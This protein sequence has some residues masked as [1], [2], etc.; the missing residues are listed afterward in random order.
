MPKRLPPHVFDSSTSRAAARAVQR[1]VPSIARRVF[2]A[3][4]VNPA[5]CKELERSLKLLHE[6]ASA[7]VSELRTAGCIRTSGAT[8]HSS[9]LAKADVYE[10]V[11]GAT[12][13]LYETW[14][15][16]NGRTKKKRVNT[17][18]LT[19]AARAYAKAHHDKK[20]VGFLSPEVNALLTAAIKAFPNG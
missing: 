7:R 16:T 1:H 19:T 4:Q 5:T 10:A 15:E 18:E 14:R 11:P 8:R 12:F 2:A 13:D 3:L 20:P 17:S 6:T 9:R